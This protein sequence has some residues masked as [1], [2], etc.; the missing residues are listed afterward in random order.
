MGFKKASVPVAAG[1]QRSRE[2]SEI[3][4]VVW[5]S[6]QALASGEDGSIATDPMPEEDVD[7]LLKR[8]DSA[9]AFLNKSRGTNF[10]VK[11][12][13]RDPSEDDYYTVDDEGNT[14]EIEIPDDY[15]VVAFKALNRTERLSM[16]GPR[17]PRKSNGAGETAEKPARRSRK[18][19]DENAENAEGSDNAEQPAY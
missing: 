15:V 1:N 18:K 11:S 8:L 13:V 19:T 9:A 5:E 3:D 2:Q 4:R 10:R 14:V 16:R 6:Y 7:Q 12:E 17:G